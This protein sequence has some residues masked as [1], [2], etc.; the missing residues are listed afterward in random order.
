MFLCSSSFYLFLNERLFHFQ[1]KC[2]IEIEFSRCSSQEFAGSVTV[3][4]CSCFFTTLNMLTLPQPVFFLLITRKWKSLNFS[5]YVTAI[6]LR[7]HRSSGAFLYNICEK[8][9]SLLYLLVFFPDIS[10][11]CDC[12]LICFSLQR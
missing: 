5:H 10:R 12:K 11:S 7:S 3:L 2:C 8:F 9:P 4:I 1:C 6:K